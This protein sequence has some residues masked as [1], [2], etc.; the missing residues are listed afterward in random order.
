MGKDNRGGE[1]ASST[2]KCLFCSMVTRGWISRQF[3][4]H[5]LINRV[6]N[7]WHGDSLRES[8]LL[9]GN[10]SPLA[11]ANASCAARFRLRRYVEHIS[12][13]NNVIALAGSAL[14]IFV[15]IPA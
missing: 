15:P 1:Q 4:Y 6:D 12:Y 7:I 13:V 14:I 5:I 8:S 2:L 3:W 9:H 11:S 10:S